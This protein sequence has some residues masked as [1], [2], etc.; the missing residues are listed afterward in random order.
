MRASISLASSPPT[1]RFRTLMVRP[2]KRVLRSASSRLGEVAAGELAP[3]P[4]VEDEPNATMVM[5]SP[6]ARRRAMWVNVCPRRA[7]SAGAVQASVAGAVWARRLAGNDSAAAT[8]AQSPVSH[9]VI[10]SLVRTTVG[11]PGVFG[12]VAPPKA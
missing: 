7:N 5:G 12:G 1:P 6:E 11:I 8:I 2:G 4:A 3:A 10:K 9:W